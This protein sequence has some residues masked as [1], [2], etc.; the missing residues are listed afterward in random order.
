MKHLMREH[1][2]GEPIFEESAGVFKVTCYC[3]GERILDLVP[4]A[5][6]VDLREMRLNEL[7][8]E[9]LRLMVNEGLDLLHCRPLRMCHSRM[10]V[11]EKPAEPLTAMRCQMSTAS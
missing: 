8:I 3:P 4:Q 2:Q 6:T 11:G 9:V 7:Q 10:H 1:G 5:G